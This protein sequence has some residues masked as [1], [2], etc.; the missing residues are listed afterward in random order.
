[1][2]HSPERP[3]ASPVRAK[4]SSRARARAQRAGARHDEREV[5]ARRR[6]LQQRAE[7]SLALGSA[8]EL[9][10][11]VFGR[12]RVVG[13]TP[14]SRQQFIHEGLLGGKG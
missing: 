10:R 9:R 5:D 3:L 1:M 2:T 6:G 8:S 13:L 7:H 4:S 12:G 14:E 11:T